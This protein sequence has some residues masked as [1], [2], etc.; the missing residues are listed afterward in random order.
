MNAPRR[1]G[2]RPSAGKDLRTVARRSGRMLDARTSP[3]GPRSTSVAA[4]GDRVDESTAYLC[5]AR[6][7]AA[8]APHVVADLSSTTFMDRAGY[9]A[10]M[11]ARA[12]IEHRGGTFELRGAG[13]QPSRLLGVIRRSR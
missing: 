1:G 12:V 3:S 2:R 13:G 9:G 8:P 7:V 10:L 6:C 5:F 11:S 4:L